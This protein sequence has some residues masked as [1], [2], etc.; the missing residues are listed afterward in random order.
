MYALQDVFMPSHHAGPGH[1]IGR[2]LLLLLGITNYILIAFAL[3]QPVADHFRLTPALQRDVRDLLDR[4]A[5]S[6][7]DYFKYFP[8]DKSYYFGRHVDGFIAY[9]VYRSTCVALADPIAANPARKE[10]LL[11]EF[12]SFCEAAGWR[13]A[14]ITVSEAS[15]HL[16]EST[17]LKTVK[18]GETAQV[19]IASY[20][21]GSLD[22]KARNVVNRFSK[23][24]YV[25]SFERPHPGLLS[26]LRTVSESW[27]SHSGRKEYQFAMGYFKDDYLKQCRIF[28]VRDDTGEL[29]A[30]VNLQPNYSTTKVAS[31]DMM[32]SR[33]TAPPNTMDYILIELIKALH[34]E[35]W[36]RL[37]LGLAPLSGLETARS[38]NERG[39]HMLYRYANRWYAF[40]GLRRFKNKFQPTWEPSYLAYSGSGAQLPAIVQAIN[41]IVKFKQ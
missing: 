38:F 22:K 14:F 26:E 8:Q 10:Q 3:L 20:V 24:G 9:G 17:E 31:I 29:V 27:L 39:L 4:Y 40:H 35:Q 13:V 15:R 2:I 16:Y 1:I 23:L 18:I 25:A 11:E 12:L 6:S 37:D 36:Q 34:H 32:R 33:Q 7:E 41:E 21:E 19:A 5:T 30:F 28:T